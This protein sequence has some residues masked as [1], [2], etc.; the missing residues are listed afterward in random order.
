MKSF[1]SVLLA[2]LILAGCASDEE[3]DP[4]ILPPQIDEREETDA[5]MKNPPVS[6]VRLGSAMVKLAITPLGQVQR[7]LSLGSIQQQGQEEGKTHW[8]CYTV[9]AT[10]SFSRVWLIATSSGG[11]DR[12][13]GVAIAEITSVGGDERCPLLPSSFQPAAFDNGVW[14]RMPREAV[15]TKL[16]QPSGVQGNELT[17]SYE[18][19]QTAPSE[20]PGETVDLDVTSK[21]EVELQG[22]FA[23]R[24]TATKTSVVD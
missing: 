18:G 19:E 6:E 7:A 5:T 12:R 22:G 1:V 10:E 2:A 16:G 11:A 24:L 23:V 8:L 15:I 14:L 21:F 20:T 17:Y 3:I 4:R 9:G 13:V